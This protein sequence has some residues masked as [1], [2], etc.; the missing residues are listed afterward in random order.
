MATDDI[1]LVELLRAS[2]EVGLRRLYAAAEAGNQEEAVSA[3]RRPHAFWKALSNGGPVPSQRTRS[4]RV[5][6]VERRPDEGRRPDGEAGCRTRPARYGMGAVNCFVAAPVASWSR[7][8]AAASLLVSALT[9]FPP[10]V[11]PVG[12]FL[13]ILDLFKRVHRFLVLTFLLGLVF[14]LL[15]P[16]HDRG[17]V[18]RVFRTEFGSP[19]LVASDG[20]VPECLTRVDQSGADYPSRSTAQPCDDQTENKRG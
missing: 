9:L 12:L 6:L 16:V 14:L 8:P 17:I 5:G 19:S 15:R 4:D 7:S 13:L 10:T 18:V 20:P 1:D 2:L 3:I 11:R